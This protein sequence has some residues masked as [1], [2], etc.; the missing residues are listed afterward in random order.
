MI[1]IVLAP[2]TFGLSLGFYAA[3]LGAI[4]YS[5]WRP[6]LPEQTAADGTPAPTAGGPAQGEAAPRP[7]PGFTACL[8]AS[9]HRG[10]A[11][12]CRRADPDDGAAGRDGG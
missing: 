8:A 11:D 9:G 12:R 2:V 6:D 7:V 4:S 5:V 10:R 3:G 1:K